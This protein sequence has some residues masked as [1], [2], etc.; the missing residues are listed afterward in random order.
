MRSSRD[1]REYFEASAKPYPTS[2][3]RSRAANSPASWLLQ[4]KVHGQGARASTKHSQASTGKPL[5]AAAALRYLESKN[6]EQERSS[7]RGRIAA[8]RA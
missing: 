4:Q 3:R 5:T 7:E 8:P 1:R 6:L 2:T